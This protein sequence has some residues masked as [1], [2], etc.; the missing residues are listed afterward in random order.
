M[1]PGCACV[2]VYFLSVEEGVEEGLA[3][4]VVNCDCVE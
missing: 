4:P 2:C 1:K 3:P